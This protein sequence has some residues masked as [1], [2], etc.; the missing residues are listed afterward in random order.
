MKVTEQINFG[1]MNSVTVLDQ[2]DRTTSNKV[3]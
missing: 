2:H 3:L 1:I